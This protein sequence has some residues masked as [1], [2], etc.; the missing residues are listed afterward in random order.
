VNGCWVMFISVI[1]GM[2][3]CSAC[4][5]SYGDY[6]C[7]AY[8]CVASMRYWHSRLVLVNVPCCALLVP[9]LMS[10]AANVV[11]KKAK[12]R[13]YRVL[14]LPGS[15]GANSNAVSATGKPNKTVV[16]GTWLNTIQC[17]SRTD[18]LTVCC[19]VANGVAERAQ[20]FQQLARQYSLPSMLQACGGT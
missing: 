10:E 11:F 5:L 20:R 1:F 15:S 2:S 19:V 12:E 18:D 17:A 13:V 7:W 4:S 14:P 6:F 9:R 16:N 3:S 8:R